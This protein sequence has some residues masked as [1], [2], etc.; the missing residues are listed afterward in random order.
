M[1]GLNRD[2]VLKLAEVVLDAA[3]AFKDV[4]SPEPEAPVGKESVG[5][6]F[7]RYPAGTVV[8][9]VIDKDKYGEST[10]LH[11]K[12][13]DGRWD[14]LVISV[15]PGTAK[16]K[17]RHGGIMSSEGLADFDESLVWTVTLLTESTK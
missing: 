14:E 7:D 13:E 17:V 9:T 8:S 5:N 12:R 10:F 11:V 3:E 15:E 4:L 1:S 16:I 6:K 2:G